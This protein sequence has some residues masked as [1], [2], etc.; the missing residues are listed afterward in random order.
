MEEKYECHGPAL[1]KRLLHELK[2]QQYALAP[3]SKFLVAA[4][5]LGESG[6]VY[7]GVNVEFPGHPH[8]STIHAEQCAIAN[9]ALSGETRLVD[10]VVNAPP[11]GHCRQFM[12]ELYGVDSLGIH[13]IDADGSLRASS[14]SAL[15]PEDFG[16]QHLGQQERLLRSQGG[17]GLVL[18]P[19]IKQLQD[20]GQEALRAA[21]RAYAP[22]SKC[23]AGV[24]LR[25][26][27][28]RLFGGF[29]IESCAFNPS[30]S[31]LQTAVVHAISKGA[32]RSLD[33]ID[34]IALVE[35][36]RAPV[37]FARST[38]FANKRMHLMHA[39]RA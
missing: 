8:S 29:L 20:I 30:L 35:L 19:Q 11:C 24:A 5:A 16:P 10:L 14:T 22:Y 37:S 4:A 31:P 18:P 33:E 32:L 34:E 25:L 1:L 9:A 2:V 36:A 13:V 38:Y 28:G 26:R 21:N 3:V 15:L 27:D 23:P 17:H 39:V 6:A 12:N 7:F